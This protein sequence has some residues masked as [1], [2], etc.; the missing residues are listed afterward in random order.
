MA[1][2]A[3]ATL[4]DF[5]STSYTTLLRSVNYPDLSV[6]YPESK[7]NA[8]STETDVVRE[9]AALSAEVSCGRFGGTV[10]ERE[11]PESQA[12]KREHPGITSVG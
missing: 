7:E 2:A 3:P 6:T 8:A 4:S 5:N 1:A 12:R 9:V 10:V 11:D